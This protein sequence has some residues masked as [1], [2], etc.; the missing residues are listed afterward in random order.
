MPIKIILEI[1]IEID[2]SFSGKL[3]KGTK[4]IR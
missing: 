2:F 4:V 1:E 3:H